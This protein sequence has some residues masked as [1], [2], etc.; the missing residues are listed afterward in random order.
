[1]FITNIFIFDLG[2]NALKAY[3][4][5]HITGSNS[6]NK[7]SINGFNVDVLGSSIYTGLSSYEVLSA[8][9]RQNGLGNVLFWRSAKAESSNHRASGEDKILSTTIEAIIGVVFLQHGAEK[10]E[11]LLYEKFFSGGNSLINIAAKEVS[12]PQTL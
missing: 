8:F 10:L 7:F 9:G 3:I 2:H 12:K 5:L 4:S 6:A 11:S 1:M